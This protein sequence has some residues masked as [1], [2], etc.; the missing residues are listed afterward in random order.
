MIMS[1]H[2]TI[3]PM[4][5]P[6]DNPVRR[7]RQA[8]GWSQA[9]LA[10]RAE[11][12]RTAVSAIES[13]RLVPSVAAALALA[14]TLGCTV[15]ELFAAR[16]SHQPQAPQFAWLPVSFPCRYW[17][18]EVGGRTLLFPVENGPRGG[19]PHDGVAYSPD[20]RGVSAS[21]ATKTLIVAG[22]DPAAGLLAAIYRRQSG[23][24][25][26][27]LTRTSGESLELLERGLIH[28][29]G[30]HLADE[31]VGNAD[32]LARRGLACD[33][34]LLHVARW[35][36]GL[37]FEP[38]LALKSAAAAAR[39]KLRWIGRP[40]GA[41]ARR[42]QDLVRGERPAPRFAARDH[43]GVVEAVRSGWAD[44][45]VSIRL[46]SEEGRLGFLPVCQEPYDLCYRKSDA[47]DPRLA[48]LVRAVRTSEYRHVL[49][50]LPGY[51]PQ[52]LGEVED[53]RAQK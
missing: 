50:E 31:R 37:A 49:G 45:G 18:A 14:G 40:P 51:Q 42:C 33:L 43:R 15:E 5:S 25:M 38:A 32:A 41:G 6:L 17:T 19:L 16:V 4:R 22:C 10:S 48:A 52:N 21:P 26:L 13:Q 29:A 9:E 24:R 20:V 44:V 47:A 3:M 39:S 2:D 12:S 30:V 46:A 27:V 1:Y 53:V 7:Q 11:I 23:L 35:E 34:K 36:E 28:V 8:R